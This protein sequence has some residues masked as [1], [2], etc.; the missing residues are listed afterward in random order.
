MKTELPSVHSRRI[1]WAYNTAPHRWYGLGRYYAMFP[2]SFAYDAISGLTEEGEPV[3][4][5]FCGRGIAPFTA[6]V[7]GRPSFGVD[8]NPIAWLFTMAKL[9][10]EEDPSHVIE[11]LEEIGDAVT[12]Q[13]RKGQTRFERMAWC[14][15]ARGFLRA[16]RRELDWKDSVTDRTLMAFI[17]LHMQDKRGSG[18]SNNLWPTIACSPQYAVKWWTKNGLRRPPKLDPVKILTDKIIRR[19]Q[20]GIP[21]QADGSAR[22]DDA[23]EALKRESQMDAS[24]LIT[25]PP[26]RGVTD[27]WNDHWIRLWLLGYR[28]RKDWKRS[29]RYEDT[30]SY[31]EL[32]YS[33]FRQSQRHLVDGAAILIRSDL[34]QR[35]AEICVDA[36]RT[37]WPDQK[38]LVS[39][40]MAP[41]KGVSAHH[42]RGGSIAK[43]CDL[44]IPGDRGANWWKNRGFR[45]INEFADQF[46]THRGR[47]QNPLP[48]AMSTTS[49]PVKPTLKLAS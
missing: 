38:L 40:S 21:K 17:A 7:L 11:R 41:H 24:L 12:P 15:D 2:P 34:R 14:P 44:L 32:I 37:V 8:I 30:E 1:P 36:M 45:P 25:S 4:D 27:Y 46:I 19:Y 29:A 18:L 26:Y 48:A 39:T 28:M 47:R 43:E 13:D 16:A 31:R 42:G 49:A 23:R 10:I 33:V 20:H 9:Q 6:T 35:T 5:P 22:L 3:L